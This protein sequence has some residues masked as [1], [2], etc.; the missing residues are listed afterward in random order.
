MTTSLIYGDFPTVTPGRLV[1]G[2]DQ[3]Q[4]PIAVFAGH[5]RAA[6][7]RKGVLTDH[8]LVDVLAAR[9]PDGPGFPEIVRFQAERHRLVAVPRQLEQGAVGPERLLAPVDLVPEVQENA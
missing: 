7:D 3:S 5:P 9:D 2:K 4:I 8:L 6:A 1:S